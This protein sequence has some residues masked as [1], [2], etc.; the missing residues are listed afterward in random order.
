M[1]YLLYL[2]IASLAFASCHDSEVGLHK[3]ELATKDSLMNQ[4]TQR[5]S[6]LL[7]YIH[8]MNEIEG[9]LKLIKTRERI[10]S[11]TQPGEF[12][13]QKD[14]IL[15][16]IKALDDL[17]VKNRREI[18]M[19]EKKLNAD[20]KQNADLKKLIM[21]LDEDLN[22][23][24]S[25]I[26]MLGAKLSRANDSV[27]LIVRQFNDSMNLLNRQRMEIAV[28]KD[29]ANSVY[30]VA[31]TY[32]DLKAKGVLTKEGGFAGIGGNA[33][34][35]QDFNTECF[36]SGLIADIHEIK[37]NGKFS[38][39]VTSHPSDTYKVAGNNKGDVF[40]IT[41]PAYFW[42]QSKYLVIITGSPEAQGS[43]APPQ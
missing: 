29:L 8:S 24:D 30:Y 25:V 15:A 5:D 38:K 19:L 21:N 28:I 14:N 43:V 41:D 35:K 16:D 11:F 2:F 3:K 17:S 1:K 36:T 7:S 37:L 40:F 13:S 39:L 12:N 20:D 10:I 27:K 18:N 26:D 42:S 4:S 6:T 34:L 32:K 9:N 22:S 33:T 23:A 31:G